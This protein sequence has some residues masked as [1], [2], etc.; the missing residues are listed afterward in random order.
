MRVA[1]TI[2]ELYEEVRDYDLVLCND[3]PLALALGNRVRRPM[4][5]VFSITPRQLAGDVALRELQTGLLSDIRLVKLISKY[6]GYDIRFVHGEVDNILRMRRY[7]ADVRPHLGKRAQRIYDELMALPTLDRVMGEFD[8]EKDGIFDGL[9]VAVIGVEL[10]DDLDKHFNPKFGTY[11][12][13]SPF[14]KGDYKIREIR[15]LGN[16]RQVAENAVGLINAENAEDVAIVMDVGGQIADAVRSAL[17]RKRIPFINSLSVKD[18]HSVRDFLEFLSLSLSFDIIRVK[19]VRELLSTYGGFIGSKY[20]EYMLSQYPKALEAGERTSELMGIMRDIREMT[21]LEVCEK[22]VRKG[23]D[24]AQV[25]ILLDEMELTNEFVEPS[26]VE[27][28]AYAV[29]NIGSLKHSEQ[30]P[31]NEKKGVLLVDCKRS[32]YIDRPFV[33]YLGMGNEWERDPHEIDFLSAGEKEDEREKNA[34]RFQILMQQGT[35]RVYICNSSKRGNRPAPCIMFGHAECDKTFLDFS[36]VCD[37]LVTD[38]W[39]SDDATEPPVIGSE[40]IGPNFI[41]KP[42]SKTQYN[43]FVECPRKFMFGTI[44]KMPDKDATVRGTM[45][46]S[47]A[48]FRV[49]YPDKVKELGLDHFADE[50]ASVCAGLSSPEK[51]NIERSEILGHISSIDAAVDLMGIEVPRLEE[52][53]EGTR[54]HFMKKLGLNAVADFSEVKCVSKDR[55]MEG[56]FDLLWNGTI[57]D[58]KTGRPINA[59]DIKSRM[60][61]TKRNDYKDYQSLFYLALLDELFPDSRGEFKLFFSKEGNMNFAKGL[62]RDI[63]GSFR[64]V[65]LMSEDDIFREYIEEVMEGI[66]KYSAFRPCLDAIVETVSEIRPEHAEDNDSE[67]LIR[68]VLSSGMKDG[69]TLR[70]N[71][72]DLAKKIRKDLSEGMVVKDKNTLMISMKALE[73]FREELAEDMERLG[74]MYSTDHPAEPICDCGKCDFADICTAEPAEGGETDV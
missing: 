4:L 53:G 20:D 34:E 69:K 54:N 63:K 8:A 19:H 26:K 44:T 64:T 17:Y 18:L 55:L 37:E 27:D 40:E 2:D 38:P 1:K 23:K 36:E 73:T 15:E 60:D 6:T 41:P 14:K 65:R 43:R 51:Y 70:K 32:V 59:S 45:I 21:F 25:K 62:E 46:H 39:V 30:I 33:I 9:R 35:A 31:E 49:C 50:I 67:A 66:K 61:R 10:Y 74:V 24:S 7:T 22:A 16:D 48:E 47:F 42:F 52:R 28:I 5:G 72:Q 12:E 11:D 71:V 29:N 57:Y 56:V 68:A 3:A 13:I 58:F